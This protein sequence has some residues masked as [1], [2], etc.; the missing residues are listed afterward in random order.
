MARN[1]INK[2]EL[3]KWARNLVRR[4]TRVW[5]A[6]NDGTLLVCL[7]SSMPPSARFQAAR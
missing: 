1:G 4:P 6:L 5:S 7:P 2:R 3:D